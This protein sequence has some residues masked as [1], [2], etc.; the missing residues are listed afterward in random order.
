M[1]HSAFWICLLGVVAVF[2]V[3]SLRKTLRGKRHLD[4]PR[5]DALPTDQE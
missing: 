3:V 2:A 4:S 5:V 1:D